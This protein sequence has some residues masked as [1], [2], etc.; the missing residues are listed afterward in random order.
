MEQLEEEK[1]RNKY[2]NLA[3]QNSAL[4]RKRLNKNVKYFDS[5]DY[6][7]AKARV[8]GSKP[9]IIPSTSPSSDVP[10]PEVILP[11]A[12]GETI[13]T[14]ENV[15]AMRKKTNTFICPGSLMQPPASPTSGLHANPGLLHRASL[16]VNGFPRHTQ[17]VARSQSVIVPTSVA[18]TFHVADK[19]ISNFGNES[20]LG[21]EHCTDIGRQEESPTNKFGTS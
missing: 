8:C 19:E 16:H 21:V 18:R 1:L 6:N 7:M 12:T 20:K 13:P 5:G 2:P 3:K 9:T 4:L 11:T 17:I 10:L 14:V 15:P